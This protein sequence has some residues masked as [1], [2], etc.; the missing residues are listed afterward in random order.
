MN[1]P[2][3]SY[4][5]ICVFIHMFLEGKSTSSFKSE[6]QDSRCNWQ[7]HCQSIPHD[8]SNHPR[9]LRWKSTW[10][11]NPLW[12]LGVDKCKLDCHQTRSLVVSTSKKCKVKGSNKSFKS[13]KQKKTPLSTSSLFLVNNWEQLKQLFG[14]ER[15]FRTP[16]VPF[17]KWGKNVPMLRT[18]DQLSSIGIPVR[19]STNHLTSHKICL[20]RHDA[21][22]PGKHRRTVADINPTSVH[23]GQNALLQHQTAREV[24]K[25]LTLWVDTTF[26][27]SHSNCSLCTNH[28]ITHHGVVGR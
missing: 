15:S 18:I 22:L 9:R 26:H 17:K 3:R 7:L 1:Y 28:S 20:T 2:L 14:L 27:P 5:F 16:W 10:V 13:L 4:V 6:F 21:I 24:P 25:C 11:G 8:T 23:H 12:Q 19:A